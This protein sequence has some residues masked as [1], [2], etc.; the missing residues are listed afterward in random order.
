MF[1]SRSFTV[2]HLIS[3]I[4]KLA[5]ETGSGEQSIALWSFSLSAFIPHVCISKGQE[6]D[7][8]KRKSKIVFIFEYLDVVL[9]S[10]RGK[11]GVLSGWAPFTAVFCN[12]LDTVACTYPVDGTALFMRHTKPLRQQQALAAMDMAALSDT[13]LLLK[14]SCEIFEAKTTI[15]L[16]LLALFAEV[17]M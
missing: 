1:K 4:I 9:A 16:F 12:F 3:C 14:L 6:R 13:L 17:L 2:W 15:F 8:I 11:G 10:E 7:F 5:D